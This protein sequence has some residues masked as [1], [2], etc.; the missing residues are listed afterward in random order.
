MVQAAHDWK[1]GRTVKHVLTVAGFLLFLAA[2]SPAWGQAAGS[3]ASKAKATPVAASTRPVVHVPT[4]PIKGPVLGGVKPVKRDGT[5][6]KAMVVKAENQAMELPL[7]KRTPILIWADPAPI[8][9]GQALTGRELDAISNVPGTF[10]F[11]PAAGYV[12]PRGSYT[13]TVQ[14]IPMDSQR[15][16][17]ASTT[18][19]LE[20]E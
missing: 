1:G 13:L 16:N 4:H 7:L 9:Q 19:V 18:A 6:N 2:G 3:D 11:S 20:V 10:V 12:P 17:L 14:F 5:A 8:K 15:Y